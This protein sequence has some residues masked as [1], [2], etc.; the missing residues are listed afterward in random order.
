MRS[1]FLPPI[2]LQPQRIIGLLLVVMMAVQLGLM[3][4]AEPDTSGVYPPVWMAA[5][6]LSAFLW[7]GLALLFP[8]GSNGQGVFFSLTLIAFLGGMFF[9]LNWVAFTA[10]P[11]ECSSSISIPFLQLNRL[12]PGWECRFVFGSVG[13]LLDG[14]LVLGLAHFIAWSWNHAPWTTWVIRAGQ[15]VAGVAALPFTLQIAFFILLAKTFEFWQGQWARII[16]NRSRK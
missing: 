11:L 10:G 8:E 1:S 3:L 16:A 5:V 4:T 15:V 14:L 6:L 12:T 13:I 7:V 2:K 9:V